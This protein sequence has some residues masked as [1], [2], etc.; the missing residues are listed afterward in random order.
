MNAVD[1][2]GLESTWTGW[3]PSVAIKPSVALPPKADSGPHPGDLLDFGKWWYGMG[4]GF[5]NRDDFMQQKIK[6][7]YEIPCNEDR[8]GTVC[9]T[10]PRKVIVFLPPPP[11]FNR[12]LNTQCQVI[13]LKG[14]KGCECPNN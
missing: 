14:R 10:P 13:K 8:T 1:P 3:N 9:F 7:E 5:A 6:L 2:W 4:N 11:L 12:Q